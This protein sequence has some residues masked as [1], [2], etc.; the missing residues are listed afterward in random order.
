MNEEELLKE[1]HQAAL[2]GELAVVLELT[3]FRPGD[4]SQG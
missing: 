3:N 1:M 4:G 2:G